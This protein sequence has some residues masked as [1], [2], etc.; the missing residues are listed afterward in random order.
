MSEEKKAPTLE[1]N[2][3]QIEEIIAQ[4][5]KPDISLD[6][7]FALYQQGVD[8]LKTCNH[9]LDAVEKKMQIMNEEGELEEF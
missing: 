1:D 4:M 2:F 8:K 3:I 9:M 7:S 5:E 6:D